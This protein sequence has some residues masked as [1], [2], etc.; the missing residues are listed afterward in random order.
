MG[1]AGRATINEKLPC[2]VYF[3][4]VVARFC[5]EEQRTFWEVHRHIDGLIDKEIIKEEQGQFIKLWLRANSQGDIEDQT[6]HLTMN[7]AINA[8]REF[9]RWCFDHMNT[10]L[11][12]Q[13]D[14]KHTA[15]SAGSSD[16]DIAA[17][18]RDMSSN[19]KGVSQGQGHG[20]ADT[21][22]G[23]KDNAIKPYSSYDMAC[24]VAD[25]KQIP[26]IWGLFK[27]SKEV[28]DHRLNI[29]KCMAVWAKENGIPIDQSIFFL[30]E[31]IEDIVK[32]RPNPGGATA[33]LKTAERGTSILACLMRFLGAIKSIC[34]RETAAEESKPN[35][36]ALP[37]FS[38]AVGSHS[39]KYLGAKF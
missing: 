30:K 22:G 38:T 20:A 39:E 3:P 26:V 36:I 8:A 25:K 6:L 17:A 35:I 31:T 33:S 15:G 7:P 18:L 32:L 1:A 28:E 12:M 19:V 11:R 23:T 16:M 34:I 29:S 5:A 14:N 2:L 27:T 24:A 9:T 21:T 37:Y 10:N 13:N 4:A